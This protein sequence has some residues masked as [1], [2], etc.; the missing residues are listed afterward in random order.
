LI[1]LCAASAH[2]I[3]EKVIREYKANERRKP[4]QKINRTNALADTKDILVGL[5]IIKQYYKAI[6][7][8][9]DIVKKHGI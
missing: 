4:N 2:P 7:A 8:S 1:T 3:A 6:K 9:D 5:F